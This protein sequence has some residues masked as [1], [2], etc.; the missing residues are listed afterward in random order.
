[1]IMALT[2]APELAGTELLV[3]GIEPDNAGSAGCL[4]KAGFR[5]LDPEPDWEGIVYYA[6]RRAG[7]SGT[8]E[9]PSPGEPGPDQPQ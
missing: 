7:K 5:P 3:A 8:T 1:M 2:A 4:R 6:W 9:G